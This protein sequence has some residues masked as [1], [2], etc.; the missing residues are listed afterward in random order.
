MEAYERVYC[1]RFCGDDAIGFYHQISDRYTNLV[2]VGLKANPPPERVSKNGRRKNSKPRNL[3][4]RL[5]K[6]KDEVLSFIRDPRIPFTNNLAERDL[7]P[8]KIQQKVSGTF[9]SQKGAIAYCRIAG[10]LSTLRK[11][12]RN[13]FEALKL[14]VKG[15]V[16]PL[17]KIIGAE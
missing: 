9:R 2:N 8:L 4:L 10:Y 14:L 12:G 5:E 15:E 16:I 1:K 13:Q 7:R 11:N 3:L 6:T 17:S